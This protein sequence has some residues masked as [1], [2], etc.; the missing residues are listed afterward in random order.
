MNDSDNNI[1][2]KCIRCTV[3]LFFILNLF[4]LN[5]VIV[6]ANEYK[7]VKVGYYQAKGFQEEDAAASL[8]SG[9]GYEYLQKVASYTGWKYEYITGSWQE[10]Y[11]KLKSGE[12]D[13]MAGVSY[14][15]Q[16][17]RE[18]LYPDYEML[19][20]TFYIYKDSNDNSMKS[21]E[22]S[23]YI[24]KRIGVTN[25]SKMVNALEQWKADTDS[26]IE[27]V[28]FDDLE[29][30]AEAFNEHE[31]DGFV[32][33][34]NIVSGYTGIS[35]VEM[36]G[37]VPYYICVS[38]QREDLL[39]E[40]NSALSLINGQDSV[41]LSN[42]K[43]KYSADTS[44]SIFLSRQEK[45]WMETHPRIIVGYLDHYLP[46]SDEAEDGTANGL[47]K[48]VISDLFQRLPGNYEP[49]VTYISYENQGQMIEAL[50]QKQVDL[51]FPVG[52]E[53][54]YAEK[55]GY[56]SSS[57]IIPAAV[58]LVYAG[59]YNAENV[60]KIAVNKNN[61]LQFEFTRIHYPTAQLIYYESA[62]DCIR[63]VKKGNADSTLVEALR[64]VNLVGADKN[65]QV[66]PLS[67]TC[68]ICFGVDYGNS[69]LLCLLNH[70]LSM[71]GDEYGL[72]HAYQYMADV[73]AYNISDFVRLHIWVIYLLLGILAAWIL[74]VL[75]I[76]YQ[77][78]KKLSQEEARYNQILQSA[79][80]KAH[81]AN[82]AKQ[83]FLN[84]MS[85]DIRTPL[86]AILGFIEINQRCKDE[87]KISE[88]RKKA[89]GCVNQLLEMMDNLIEMSKLEN[90]QVLDMQENVDLRQ[91]VNF[92]D[93]NFREQSRKVEIRFI[94]KVPE[95]IETWPHVYG[96]TTCI[97]EILQHILE[98]AIK[99]NRPEGEVCWRDELKAISEEQ[100][101]Y[102]FEVVDTGIGM[103][104]EFLKHIFEP[105]SQ[106]RY[107]ARTTYKGSG[108]GMAIV[109][110]LLEQ[111]NGTIKIS[112]KEG[113]GTTVN[114]RIPLSVY[115]EEPIKQAQ[116]EEKT[117]YM[118]TNTPD[119]SGI[120]VL[121]VEDNEL[122][123]EIAKF[124]LEDAG[125]LVT[126]AMDGEQAVSAYLDADPGEYDAVLM[127]IMMPVMN[128][129]EA[130][131]RIRTSGRSDSLVVPIIATTACVT[132]DAR[133]EGE[134]AGFT[135]FMTKPLDMNKLLQTIWQLLRRAGQ[136]NL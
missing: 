18:I 5:G 109:K 75:V 99:Y 81:Q 4:L 87:V 100:V 119:F 125:A 45:D 13:L 73:A 58:D 114:I 121:L 23:S 55:N 61:L 22:V 91:I 103:K 65:L 135:T 11:D 54:P 59:N 86:N 51:V 16:R 122:N 130:T 64:A 42:L 35:P 118:E 41:Y 90:G 40:L 9:Y 34:D 83:V 134:S 3:M 116:K 57:V 112:S 6:Y 31:I 93:R 106:E 89:A 1:H 63:A 77:S 117:E 111:M 32:S 25:D 37:R 108:L 115:K 136:N 120:H 28:Q 39:D 14:D 62:E 29:A 21:G 82:Y 128:G 94:H 98:N 131:R 133:K 88:N 85:H 36:I 123:I 96:N 66:V 8:K 33:A 101:E 43:N 50:K 44:I 71:L 56:Q 72:S 107:D 19:K 105:F 67:S 12:I 60:K 95:N 69:E 84:N 97:Q 2:W 92:L 68:D 132:E 124:M 10:L 26:E 129:Y 15:G 53:L 17:S 38:K 102:I 104:E 74:C 46:Y 47:I 126:V 113:K 49:E 110:M 27:M 20:E 76:R 52:G 80:M 7:T 79:L 48:D 70:G 127:D 78:M 30:C 24:G